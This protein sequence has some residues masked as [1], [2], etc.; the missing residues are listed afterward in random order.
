M[1]SVDMGSAAQLLEETALGADA[2]VCTWQL[3][4]ARE[5]IHSER[6][7]VHR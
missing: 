1:T 6:E 2:G 3:S 4:P 5:L 7:Y